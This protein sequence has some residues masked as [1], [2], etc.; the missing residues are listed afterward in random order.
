M[1]TTGGSN[2]EGAARESV[3]RH[4]LSEVKGAPRKEEVGNRRREKSK[5]AVG[6]DPSFRGTHTYLK[7]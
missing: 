6:S 7:E 5:V 1:P 4:L 2:Y 3:S